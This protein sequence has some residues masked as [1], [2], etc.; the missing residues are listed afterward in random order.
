M[1]RNSTL[2]YIINDF[3]KEPAMLI[4]TEKIVERGA[5]SDNEITKLLNTIKFKAPPKAVNKILEYAGA[6]IL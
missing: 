5:K 6:G 1:K 3:K 2:H 4:E